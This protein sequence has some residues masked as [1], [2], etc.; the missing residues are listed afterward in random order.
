MLLPAAVDDSIPP[1]S[2][3]RAI[4]ALGYKTRDDFSEGPTDYCTV[5]HHHW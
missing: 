5:A 1:A 4:D 3:V 2:L